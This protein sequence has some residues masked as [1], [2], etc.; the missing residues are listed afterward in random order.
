MTT[1]KL[2]VRSVTSGS[3]EDAMDR[4]AFL[5][6]WPASALLASCATTSSRDGG[7]VSEDFMIAGGDPDVRLFVHNKRGRSTGERARPERTVLFV[8][9][10]TYPGSAAFDLPLDGRSWMDDLAHHGF[11]TWCVDVRG[12]GRSTRPSL[13]EQPPQANAPGRVAATATAD[14]AAAVH[15][16]QRQRGLDRIAIVAWSWG[17]VLSARFAASEPRSVERLVLYAPVWLW[18]GDA[19]PPKAPPGAYRQVTRDIARRIWLNGVPGDQQA[20]LIPAGWFDQWADANWAT[21]PLGAAATPPTLRAPNGP[22]AEV[23]A[24]WTDGRPMHGDV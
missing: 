8:H 13:M 19:P 4:R 24:H 16:N 11:D 14:V 9:G 3:L 1:P 22:L 21:D 10:L 2:L 23:I 20:S 18:R 5:L 12:Y 6:S 17:T 7:L 15:F